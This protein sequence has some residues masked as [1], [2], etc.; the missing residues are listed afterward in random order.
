LWYL[1]I[2]V[3]APIPNNIFLFTEYELE[4]EM[5]PGDISFR[6]NLTST[7]WLDLRECVADST[8]AAYVDSALDTEGELLASLKDDNEKKAIGASLRWALV[9]GDSGKLELML[10][11]LPLPKTYVVSKPLLRGDSTPIIA[12]ASFPLEY[13]SFDGVKADGPVPVIFCAENDRHLFTTNEESVHSQLQRLAS[14]FAKPETIGF[15]EAVAVVKKPR[16]AAFELSFK[17]KFQ[18]QPGDRQAAKRQRI[19]PQEEAGNFYLIMPMLSSEIISLVMCE[20]FLYKGFFPF[21]F[22]AD[23]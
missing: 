8:I 16:L 14:Y 7:D 19:Q 18:K 5:W 17:R 3:V 22:S 4:F 11:A 23:A 12:I 9:I 2:N 20:T 21:V 15:R 10:Q 1:C 6:Q 13:A